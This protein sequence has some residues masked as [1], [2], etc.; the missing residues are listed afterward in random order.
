[1]P[2]SQ[3]ENQH[4]A[5]LDVPVAVLMA[6]IATLLWSFAGLTALMVVAMAYLRS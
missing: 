2:D 1:M 5:V 3:M 4:D 6:V